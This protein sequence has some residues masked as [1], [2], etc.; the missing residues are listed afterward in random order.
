MPY[1]GTPEPRPQQTPHMMTVDI[2]ILSALCAIATGLLC[3]FAQPI[4]ARLGLLD[5]P[6]GRKQHKTATPLVGGIVLILVILPLTIVASLLP[7]DTHTRAML[8]YVL[9]TMGIAMVGIADDRHSLS[10][11]ARIILT[12]LI[13]AIAAMAHPLYNVRILSFSFLDFDLG[14]GAMP[15]AII[16]TTICCVGL[17]NAVNMADGKNGLVLGLCLG[18]L[19]ILGMHAAPFML[20]Y[21]LLLGVGVLVMLAFNMRG[22]LFLGDGGA[23]GFAAAIG[24]LSIATYNSHGTQFNRSI[25]AEELMLMFSVPVIDSFRLTFVRWRR[26]QSPMHGDRDHLH[27]HLLNRFGWPVGLFV[28]WAIALVPMFLVMA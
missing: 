15:F 12:M 16:F 8:V 1:G 19:V 14:L 11:R 2:A 7:D 13:F 22:K 3:W 6:E 27:H 24:L 17:V 23:Y 4:C 28:Y 18:W 20:P 10:A 21:I 25:H 9:A 26:G 5:I